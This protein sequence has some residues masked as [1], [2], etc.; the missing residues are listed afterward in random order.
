[1]ASVSLAALIAIKP[2]QRPRLIY[3]V[4][5]G[6][7]PRKDRYKAFTE[8]DYARL[9]D[10]AHQQPGGPNVVV[11]DYVVRTQSQFCARPHYVAEAMGTAPLAG[12]AA[13]LKFFS[14]PVTR[15]TSGGCGCIWCAP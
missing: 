1:V 9:L 11:W 5:A 15:G 4:H 13:E 10:A 7:G 6:R 12:G 3:R 14:A 8:A 2:G